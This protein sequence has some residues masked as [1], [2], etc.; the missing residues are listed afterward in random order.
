MKFLTLALTVAVAPLLHAQPCTLLTE[1]FREANRL[2]NE[3][4]EFQKF[5]FSENQL[6]QVKLL[7]GLEKAVDGISVLQ[8]TLDQDNESLVRGHL[9]QLDEKLAMHQLEALKKE[10]PETGFKVYE[11]EVLYYKS[12]YKRSEEKAPKKPE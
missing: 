4:K 3:S 8:K 1:T 2:K 9:W 5:R 12:K 11:D 10:C 7:P 6:Q